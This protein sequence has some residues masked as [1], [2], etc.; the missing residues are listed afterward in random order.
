MDI[1]KK[2][3]Q[4]IENYLLWYAKNKSNSMKLVLPLMGCGVGGLDKTD[5]IK[6][7]KYFLMREVDINCE[8][9]IYGYSTED[10]NQ[11]AKIM[12]N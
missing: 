12:K 4:N 2:A 5:V 7:Y 1:I 10:Y 9:V 8:V 11:I 6:V 3:L